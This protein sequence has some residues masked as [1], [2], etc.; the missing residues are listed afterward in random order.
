MVGG[1]GGEGGGGGDGPN[2]R[3]RGEGNRGK[4]TEGQRR[5]LEHAM[6]PGCSCTLSRM[7]LH[8]SAYRTPC[9]PY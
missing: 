9:H 4:R 7:E 8:R 6:V 5:A 3:G 2:G 1:E